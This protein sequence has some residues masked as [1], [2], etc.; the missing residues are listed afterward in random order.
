MFKLFRK[1]QE[2][3]REKETLSLK[4]C[5][6]FFHLGAYKSARPLDQGPESIHLWHESFGFSI[7]NKIKSQLYVR[8]PQIRAWLCKVTDADNATPRHIFKFY[9]TEIISPKSISLSVCSKKR[10]LTSIRILLK[11]KPPKSNHLIFVHNVALRTDSTSRPP[12]LLHTGQNMVL[13]T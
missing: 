13:C 8:A 5:N 7:P 1:S 2:E 11:N 4:I 6:I 10:L 3:K 12:Y 9:Q